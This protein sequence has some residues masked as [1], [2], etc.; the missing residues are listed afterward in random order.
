MAELAESSATAREHEDEVLKAALA[1]GMTYAAAGAVA[2]VSDRTVRRRMKEPGFAAQ[3]STM[4]GEHVAAVTGQL[5]IAGGAAVEV[6][7]DCMA[8]GSPALRLRAAHLVLTLGAQLRQAS[9]FEERLTA[10]E[11]ASRTPTAEDPSS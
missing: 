7:V 4:R 11:T 10:L 6:L 5:A 1:A 3:V 9:E 2:G 8:A